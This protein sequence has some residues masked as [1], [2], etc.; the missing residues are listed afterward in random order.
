MTRYRIQKV[1]REQIHYLCTGRGV[2]LVFF[3]GFGCAPSFYRSLFSRLAD[4]FEM[5]A[6]KMFGINYL[7]RQPV[8][9]HEYTELA[10]D[11]CASLGVKPHGIVGH[12]L[13]SLI[14][15][16]TGDRLPETACLVGLSPVLPVGY[17]L[18]GFTARA[19]YKNARESIGITGGIRAVRFGH[20][21]G[22]VAL[23]NLL[24][25]IPASIHTVKDI[26]R[27]SFCNMRVQQPT[28]ILYGERDEFF[29][30]NGKIN[31]HIKRSFAHLTIKRLNKCNHDWPIFYPERAAREI[32]T[33]VA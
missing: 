28:L 18:F 26:R 30:L 6:P 15:F 25:N 29:N 3:H 32:R 20:T 17:D 23:W 7:K 1:A 31:E 21:I 4:Q 19:I 14:A 5:I 12:S 13:G 2:P 27:F 22:P 33:F 11:F 8:S 10:L 24:K 9:I 16:K